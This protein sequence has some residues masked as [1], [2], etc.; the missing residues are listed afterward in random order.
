MF[1]IATGVA[2]AQNADEP[3]AGPQNPFGNDP[4]AVA[5]GGEV[6]QV[7]CSACHGAKGEGGSGPD[8]SRG[9]FSVGD[10]DADLQQIVTRGR[11]VMPGFRTTLG[12]QDVWRVVSFIR[13]LAG[14][15]AETTTGDAAAGGKLFWDKGGCGQCHRVTLNGGSLGPNLSTIGLKRGASHLRESILDPDADLPQGYAT[16]TVATADGAKIE[17][18]QLGYDNFSAQLLDLQNNFHSYLKSEV[19]EITRS[20]RS[21]MPAYRDVFSAS[22]IDD[23]VAYLSSLGR[24]EP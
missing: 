18:V 23:L 8:L 7:H 10:A 22:E 21:L 13:S 16:L 12:E 20:R 9:A 24:G 14:S 11:D 19:K 5:A 17:G 15:I 6:F 2:A 1:L 4:Q 3:H